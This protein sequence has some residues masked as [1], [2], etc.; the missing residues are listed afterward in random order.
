MKHFYVKISAPIHKLECAKGNLI[1]KIHIPKSQ[2]LGCRCTIWGG[3]QLS[4]C[5]QVTLVILKVV[6]LAAFEKHHTKQEI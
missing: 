5:S 3:V 6:G 2:I 4:S 1:F